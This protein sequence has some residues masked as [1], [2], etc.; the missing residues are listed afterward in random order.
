MTSSIFSIRMHLTDRSEKTP[1]LQIIPKRLS[2]FPCE[3]L[4]LVF[5]CVLHNA[6]PRQSLAKEFE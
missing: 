3:T 1:C 2:I 4:P 5:F 6:P